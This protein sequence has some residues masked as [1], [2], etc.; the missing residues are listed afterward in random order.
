MSM[1]K[2]ISMLA[3]AA[4]LSLGTAASAATVVLEDDFDYGPTSV[5]SIGPNFLLPKWTSTPTLDYLATGSNFGNL[6][7][8]TGGCIDLDGSSG[9]AGQLASADSF[10]AGTYE[11]SY[12]L[13]GSLRGTTESVTISMGSWSEVV[14]LASADILSVSGL[15][16]TT[17]GGALSFQNS[18]G[19]NI[20]AVLS[21]VTLAAVPLPAG[22]LLLLG[23]LGGIAVLRRR[24]KAA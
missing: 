15:R 22:G 11:L 12:L 4:L 13:F 8:N 19:D 24:R 10:A 7:R 3:A 17:S 16:F 23:A 20:G 5:L 14:S 9:N 6:C 1:L 18:G 21:S 2:K